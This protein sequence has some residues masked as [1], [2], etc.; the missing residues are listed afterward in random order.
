MIMINNQWYRVDSMRDVQQIVADEFSYELAREMENHITKHTD[1]EY[2]CLEIECSD[3][4]DQI[5]FL[6]DEIDYLR[7]RLEEANLD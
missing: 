7:E 1:D 4:E 5:S 3:L 6:E 2:V